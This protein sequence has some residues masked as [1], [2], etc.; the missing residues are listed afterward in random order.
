MSFLSLVKPTPVA[1]APAPAPKPGLPVRA[2]V[3][4]GRLFDSQNNGTGARSRRS[5]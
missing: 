3:Q 1:A 2:G 5:R 4:A